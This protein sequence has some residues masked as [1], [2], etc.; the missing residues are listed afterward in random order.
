MEQNSHRGNFLGAWARDNIDTPFFEHLRRNWMN[1][2]T[3]KL[4]LMAAR[5][6]L[7]GRELNQGFLKGNLKKHG[8]LLRSDHASFWY[9]DFYK[10]ITIPNTILL[11]D[12]GPWRKNIVDKYHNAHDNSTLLTSDNLNFLRN[13][14]DSIL[15]TVLDISD[16]KCQQV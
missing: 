13:T 11:T 2:Q 5:L 3:Y 7:T 10:N 12:L 8:V 4:Y 15:V 16:G 6:P 1:A 9:P 14:I